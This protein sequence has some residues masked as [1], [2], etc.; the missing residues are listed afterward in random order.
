[1]GRK[2]SVNKAKQGK[3]PNS[4]NDAPIKGDRHVIF[5]ELSVDEECESD[6]DHDA[7]DSDSNDS[8]EEYDS[9]DSDMSDAEMDRKLASMTALL[10]K[11][12][13]KLLEVHAKELALTNK[14]ITASEARAKLLVDELKDNRPTSHS[15][16][17]SSK[18]RRS[19]SSRTLNK[20]KKNTDCRG[21]DISA[22]SGLPVDSDIDSDDRGSDIHAASGLPGNQ[23]KFTTRNKVCWPHHALGHRYTD[24]ESK[25]FG[26][27]DLDMRLFAIG[28]L[29]ICMNV[30]IT[31]KE[32]E[33]RLT[34]LKD[35]LFYSKYYHWQAILKLHATILSE[36]EQGIRSWSDSIDSLIPQVLLQHRLPAESSDSY[37]SPKRQSK[38]WYCGDYNNAGCDLEDKHD[39]VINGETLRARHICAKCWITDKQRRC[40][41]RLSD[42]CPHYL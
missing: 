29:E 13:C 38:L 12:K 18:L 11:G 28:E 8:S 31:D 39:V 10:R 40:H 2:G 4:Q 26:H 36:I 41:S 6:T 27:Y 3:K 1:M 21:C 42:E 32:Q 17:T 33:A 14:A 5:D 20:A 15:I 16:S 22:T 9:D 34:R 19:S 37:F 23:S 25:R 30:N 7:S 35:L 24:F